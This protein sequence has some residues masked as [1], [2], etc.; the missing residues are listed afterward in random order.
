MTGTIWA[1]FTE[2]AFFYH[3]LPAFSS[4]LRLGPGAVMTFKGWKFWHA[5]IAP[6]HHLRAQHFSIACCH[7]T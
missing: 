6:P 5:S 4:V 3:F 1:A 2:A 7:F